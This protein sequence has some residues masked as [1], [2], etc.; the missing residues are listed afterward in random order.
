LCFIQEMVSA[1]QT[2]FEKRLG[3]FTEESDITSPLAAYE[4][5]W[6]TRK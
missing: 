4:G 1:W 5:K 3:L 2:T 6:R